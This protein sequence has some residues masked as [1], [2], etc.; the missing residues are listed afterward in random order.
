MYFNTQEWFSLTE[1]RKKTDFKASV[2]ALKQGRVIK[3][4]SLGVSVKLLI[5]LFMLLPEGATAQQT[6][7]K[8]SA[9]TEAKAVEVQGAF[10]TIV[11][12]VKGS[13][14]VYDFGKLCAE[15]QD[16]DRSCFSSTEKNRFEELNAKL[17]AI[18]AQQE[19]N[20]AQVIAALQKIYLQL[21]T[22]E[23]KREIDK[24]RSLVE[25]QIPTASDKL[26]EYLCGQQYIDAYSK[27]EKHDG[28]QITD[29]AGNFDL[30]ATKKYGKPKSVAELYQDGGELP[31]GNVHGGL[32][33][34]LV[35]ATVGKWTSS[36]NE[37][38]QEISLVS[39]GNEL[40]QAIAGGDQAAGPKNGILNAFIANLS[41][42]LRAQQGASFGQR[43]VFF[44]SE[45]LLA[46]N[47]VTEY[48]VYQEALFFSAS[49][50]ALQ[51]RDQK[52]EDNPQLTAEVLARM[53][54]YGVNSNSSGAKHPEWALDNQLTNYSVS[55]ANPLDSW[56]IL[57]DGKINRLRIGGSI[58]AFEKIKAV[59]EALEKADIKMSKL[60]ELYPDLLPKGENPAWQ[61]KLGVKH[62]K[63]FQINAT[64]KYYS[65][66]PYENIDY[67][68]PDPEP[69]EKHYFTD[70]YAVT[71]SGDCTTIV[72]MW[73]KKPGMKEVAE[74]D[75]N[76]WGGMSGSKFDDNKSGV[77][78]V[79]VI[80]RGDGRRWKGDTIIINAKEQYDA[81]VTN[82]AVP[83]YDLT[84]SS[85]FSNGKLKVF[86][87]GTLFQC[88]GKSGPFSK[89]VKGTVVTIQE[90]EIGEGLWKKLVP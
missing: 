48:W 58:P 63:R 10:G 5:C 22:S 53:A 87:V 59:K 81:Y 50:A 79:L 43:P 60:Q 31:R 71:K 77:Y 40:M 88:T 38:E 51:L 24:I 68:T 46:M 84:N 42:E 45:F 11:K 33:A 39:K 14:K 2:T 26:K 9:A 36:D 85:S 35:A 72:R 21:E 25:V 69:A 74:F 65:D 37:N 80:K 15:N 32:V 27:G 57:T 12:I 7:Q 54:E 86:G 17:D 6:E 90:Q 44:T 1:N 70:K 8:N 89:T 34:R 62:Y 13:K 75:S 66:Q 78:S 18:I 16:A 41:A 29:S 3:L 23:L 73:D 76:N 52:T 61:S 82:G 67:Y 47:E 56:V 28:C 19:E 55:E 20:Q 30:S 64:T 4:V 49:I 83:V